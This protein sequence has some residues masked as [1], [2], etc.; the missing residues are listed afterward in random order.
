MGP[1]HLEVKLLDE[2]MLC[3][4]LAGEISGVGCK[5]AVVPIMF[6]D[7]NGNE[8]IVLGLVS[9]TEELK[10][11]QKI[12]GHLIFVSNKVRKNGKGYLP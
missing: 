3:K 5:I 11:D 8:R 6:K 4:G 12:S 9:T 10:K 1:G 7:D 2:P